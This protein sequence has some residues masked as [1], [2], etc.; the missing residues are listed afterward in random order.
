MKLFIC[1]VT[2]DERLRAYFG[3]GKSAVIPPD[4]LK[5]GPWGR[6][7]PTPTVAAW[8]PDG[9]ASARDLERFI[10][11][12]ARDHDACLLLVDT[13]YDRM[14]SDIRNAMFVVLFDGA[15]I[16]GT[17]QN[18]FFGVCAR[19]LRSFAQI[20]AKFANGDDAQLLA[21]PLRNF[22][23]QDLAEI[24][25][26]CR[27]EPVSGTLS[28]DV[29]QSLSR[30]RRRVRP[31]KKSRYK[32]RYVVDDALRFF[33]YGHERH[34]RFATATPH[35]PACEVA[36]LFRFGARLDEVRHYNV[37]ETEGDETTVSG[38]FSDCHGHIHAVPEQSHLNMFAN[39]FF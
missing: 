20:L 26:L 22:L 33:K 23:A 5:R 8:A 21:L 13:A 15:A 11:Q 3:K 1:L 25:R 10:L 30:L 2:P 7:G 29:D 24:A 14:L 31:R 35:I 19:A 4:A 37:S 27:E 36:G 32:T 16:G 6:L 34:A 9:A 39:D 38:D 18:F 28:N 17:L 12:K